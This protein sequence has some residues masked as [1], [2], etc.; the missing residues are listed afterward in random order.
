ML[1]VRTN[2]NCV[3]DSCSRVLAKT[4]I[5]C[6]KVVWSCLVHSW[7]SRRLLSF[8]LTSHR[9][10]HY[11]YY[12]VSPLSGINKVWCQIGGLSLTWD[13]R[14]TGIVE[15]NVLQGISHMQMSWYRIAPAKRMPGYIM[16]CTSE[17]I[18]GFANK[19]EI[20]PTKI[21]TRC[22]TN[23]GLCLCVGTAFYKGTW[24]RIDSIYS[25]RHV[26]KPSFPSFTINESS[27]TS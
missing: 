27:L 24:K 14:V 22:L 2:R 1:A 3:G 6:H 20:T 16:R 26:H 21:K 13:H 5:L 23:H 17:Y 8:R 12:L 4:S 18:V 10:C 19:R 9:H 15:S 25:R 7:N 11:H